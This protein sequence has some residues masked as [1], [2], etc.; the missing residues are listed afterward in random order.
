MSTDYFLRPEPYYR[1]SGIALHWE[2]LYDEYEGTCKSA[3]VYTTDRD[4][5]TLAENIPCSLDFA[6][7]IDTNASLIGC[8]DKLEV[9]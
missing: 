9:I 5:Q 2:F 1:Y 7:A 6:I 4:I 3:P 8:R